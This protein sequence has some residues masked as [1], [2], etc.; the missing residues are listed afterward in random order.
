VKLKLENY[1]QQMVDHLLSHDRAYAN[2]GL[3]LGKTA[4]TLF[5]LNTLF[6]EGAIRAALIVAPKRVARMTW[7][8]EIEKWDQFRWMRVEHLIGEKPSGT[9][10]IYLINYDRLNQLESLKFCDVVVFD[11]ITRAKNPQSKRINAL[12]PMFKNQMRWGLT[13][14]PRPNSLMELFGQIRLLDDGQRLG[15]AF[16]AFR[17]AH[18]YPTDYMRYNWEPKPGSEEKV[19]DKISD[20]T[21]TLRTSDHLNVPD[22]ILEDVEVALPDHAQQVYQK[23]AKEFLSEVGEGDIIARNAAVLAGKLHQIAGG[24]AY[25]DDG[26]VSAIHDQKIKALKEVFKKVAEPVLVAC[27]YVHER[28]RIC[29]SIAGAVNAATFKGDI[30][31]AWNNWTISMLVADPRSLGHGLNLQQGGRTVIWYSPTWSRELYDQFN[32]RVVRKGQ[33]EQPL[34]YRILARDTIDEAVVETLRE[35]GNAQNEMLRVM[36]N[37]RRMLLFK[38]GKDKLNSESSE[39]TDE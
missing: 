9:A 21:I 6:Q 4:S 25:T 16:T 26:A 36:A 15:R 14:T 13:G 31:R 11:E 35:R 5:A 37:Y 38:G 23:L 3:G 7:P 27:N 8:N 10:Q 20:L 39:K 2:V 34:L 22:M 32:A 28:E 19:Y 18:F 1:Q 12:R 29:D 30:E 33:R 24:S 17:D